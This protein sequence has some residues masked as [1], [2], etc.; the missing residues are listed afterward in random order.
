MKKKKNNLTLT[1][2]YTMNPKE[3]W[4]VKA[5][6]HLLI[7]LVMVIRGYKSKF[8]II[9]FSSVFANHQTFDWRKSNLTKMGLGLWS[10]SNE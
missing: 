3:K 7:V 8:E 6:P 5:T 10:I 9:S 2:H 1:Q 4:T